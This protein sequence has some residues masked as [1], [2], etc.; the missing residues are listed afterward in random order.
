MYVGCVCVWV[1]GVCGCVCSGMCGMCVEG[2][3]CVWRRV[4]IVYEIDKVG[5]GRHTAALTSPND[6]S[7]TVKVSSSGSGLFSRIY[8]KLL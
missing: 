6:S 1:C 4:C 5:S 8:F 2:R 3:G 7:S